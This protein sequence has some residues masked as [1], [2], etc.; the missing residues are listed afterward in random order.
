MD[1]SKKKDADTKFLRL[2]SALITSD[3]TCNAKAG[4]DSRQNGDQGLNHQFPDF[5]LVHNRL[6]VLGVNNQI[7]C[8][9]SFRCGA[10]QVPSLFG[11]VREGLGLL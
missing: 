4:T 8:T 7:L 5:F 2:S 11:R 6:N 10:F 9:F 1:T 3:T